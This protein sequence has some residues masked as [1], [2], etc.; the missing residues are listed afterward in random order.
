VI[1]A[2]APANGSKVRGIL[3]GF[4]MLRRFDHQIAEKTVFLN[5]LIN[6]FNWGGEEERQ[7]QELKA[8]LRNMLKNPRNFR[9]DPT[10][11][12]ILETVASKKAIGTALIQE[13]ETEEVIERRLIYTA[14]RSLKFAE[15][16]YSTIRRELSSV[17]FALK[18]FR[19][20]LMGNHFLVRTDHRPLDGLFKKAITSIE[21]EDLRDLVAGL[22][23]FEYVPGEST[24]FPDWLSTNCVDELCSYPDFRMG[25][26]RKFYE[27]F[28]RNKW[29]RFIPAI[30]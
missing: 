5:S 21:I 20:F 24:C 9:V 27:V 16:R 28:S 22:T 29:K 3:G 23:D 19:K 6:S 26:S 8:C 14:S 11:P 4:V 30:E 10:L 17:S 1:D 12:L 15:T 13:V 2:P 18:K 25:E 7:F